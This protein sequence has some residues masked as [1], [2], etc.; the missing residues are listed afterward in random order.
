M[1]NFLSFL[2]TSLF[3][4]SFTSTLRKIVS[5]A[6]A[7]C[8]GLIVLAPAVADTSVWSVSSGER[9]VYLGGT[10]HLLR[11]GDYPLP[12]EFEQAYQASSEL[13]F[14]T[15]ISSMNS[16][17]VQAQMLQQLAYNDE[18]SLKT[19]LNEKAYSALAE[20]TAGAGLPLVMLEKF[21][22]GLLISTLQVL[23]LQSMG[24]TSQGVDVS[25]NTRAIADAKA[26]GQL[27]TVQ[28]QIGFIA[29]MG[30]NNESEFILLSLRDLEE[31]DEL[32]EEMIRAWRSGDN[33]TLA[34]MF[35]DDMKSEA[36]ELYDLLL[37]QRNL[38][39]IPQIEQMLK[40]ADTE[41]VLVG[42]AHIV[43]E[44]GLLDLLTG[45]GYEIKQL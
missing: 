36:P 9:T 33:L 35:V 42:V 32:I 18:Q 26:L 20:Y 24:F 2:L 1:N 44:N 15:D 27:E 8:L 41:F 39:W 45:K 17:A 34:E 21:K 43:G 37:L 11:P 10:V 3:T 4:F 29:A 22:P 14:E 19:V 31:T 28:Q 7:F 30:E 25:F 16:L 6:A 40:D 5:A 23:Q 38:K 12:V 13:Y